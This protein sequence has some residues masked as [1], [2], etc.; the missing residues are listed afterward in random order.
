MATASAIEKAAQV[1]PEG[2]EY[3]QAGGFMAIA[4]ISFLYGLG[5]LT[6]LFAVWTMI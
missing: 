5:R 4:L 2:K 6:S 1:W 3:L